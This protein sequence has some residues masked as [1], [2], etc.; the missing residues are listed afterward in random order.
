MTSIK[1][2][3]S[4][5]GDEIPINGRDIDANGNKR[6]DP[7]FEPCNTKAANDKH[8][9]EADARAALDRRKAYWK[10]KR[11]AADVLD[12]LTHGWATALRE[13]IASRNSELEPNSRILPRLIFHGDRA[14]GLGATDE[15][16]TALTELTNEQVK[17]LTIEASAIQKADLKLR[18]ERASAI[19]A[20]RGRVQDGEAAS[21][22][23]AGPGGLFLNIAAVLDGDAVQDFP[24]FL[25]RADGK[26][27]FY[28]GKSNVIYGD[29]DTAKTWIALAAGAEILRGDGRLAFFDLDHNGAPTIAGRLRRFGVDPAVLRDTSRFLYMDPY[30]SRHIIDAV[31]AL[32]AWQS[33]MVIIDST[34]ELLPM[35][36]ANSNSGDEFT[37]VNRTVVTPLARSGAAVVSIDHLA[38]NAESR[39]M[40][41]GGSYAKVRAVDGTMVRVFKVAHFIPGQGGVSSLWIHKDR[42]GNALRETAAPDV[43]G[44]E[45]GDEIKRDN[46]R[47]WGVFEM[48]SEAVRDPRTGKP[49]IDSNGYA[50]ER[51]HWTVKPPK[52]V[53][54]SDLG[55]DMADPRHGG[56]P[57][58][59]GVTIVGSP[60]YE[61]KVAAII[62]QLCSLRREGRINDKS[63]KTTV[64]SDFVR[65]RREPFAGAW[66]RWTDAGRPIEPKDVPPLPDPFGV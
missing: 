24:A 33:D 31:A 23:D 1:P 18:D 37:T 53:N 3:S 34:G 20:E 12:G 62:E 35:F 16:L 4:T 47:R 2:E 63:A 40:G 61:K 28:R 17:A 22:H 43:D 39:K 57:R 52:G 11:Y 55:I 65:G 9:A 14:V 26:C 64:W 29:P 66:E 50:E 54:G 42:A 44:D 21:D 49:V 13:D 30:D 56:R 25:T 7:D 6:G 32:A 48:T 58:G 41:P 19:A 36:G 27:L 60:K 59:D 8:K 5:R 15:Q 45:D 38:K 10:Q 51:L 46:L